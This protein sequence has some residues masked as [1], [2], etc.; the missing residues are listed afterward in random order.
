MAENDS[1]SSGEMEPSEPRFEQLVTVTLEK[2]T[3]VMFA[4]SPMIEIRKHA[5]PSLDRKS[6]AL[7]HEIIYVL[8]HSMAPGHVYAGAKVP[9]PLQG[10]LDE[11]IRAKDPKDST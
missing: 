2:P 10:R 4:E 6:D 7:W 3:A 5:N 9:F 8:E 1:F 11:W